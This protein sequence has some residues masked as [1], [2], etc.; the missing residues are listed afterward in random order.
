ML[1]LAQIIGIII[2]AESRMHKGAVR[3]DGALGSSRLAA[4]SVGLV[5]W[6][7]PERRWERFSGPS[8][9]A[10]GECSKSYG[11]GPERSRTASE[12]KRRNDE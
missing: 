1:T 7:C 6:S 8:R 2:L 5:S 3:G 12:T 9:A 4:R 11:Q 10:S